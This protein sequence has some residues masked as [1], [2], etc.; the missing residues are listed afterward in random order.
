MTKSPLARLESIAK[1][2]LK[3]SSKRRHQGPD[4]STGSVGYPRPATRSPFQNIRVRVANHKPS[5]TLSKTDKPLPPLPLKH[6]TSSSPPST[7]LSIPSTKDCHKQVDSILAWARQK[8]DERIKEQITR[9]DLTRTHPPID[10]RRTP[11]YELHHLHPLIPILPRTSLTPVDISCYHNDMSDSDMVGLDSVVVDDSNTSSSPCDKS[12]PIQS[13]CHISGCIKHFVDKI[14][15]PTCRG[16]DGG[17][18][19]SRCLPPLPMTSCGHSESVQGGGVRRRSGGRSV[20]TSKKSS[21][22]S[23]F[24]ERRSGFS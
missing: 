20:S 5:V 24:R 17:R 1:H 21:D 14:P 19:Q 12:S 7:A 3:K 2:E 16:S 15:R 9:R 23:F 6:V 4:A 8:R 11:D 13:G 10:Y 18:R 22:V